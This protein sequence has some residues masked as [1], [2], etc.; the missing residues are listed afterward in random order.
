MFFSNLYEAMKDEYRRWRD[1][2]PPP[3]TPTPRPRTTPSTASPSPLLPSPARVPVPLSSG[4]LP[5]VKNWSH[6][7]GDTS[8]VFQQLTTLAKAQ[9]GYFPLGRNGLWHGGVHFDSGTAGTVGP[10]GQ[11][12]VRCLADGEVIAYRIPEQTPKTLFFPAP[13]V[14]IEAPFAS[15]FVLVRHRLEAPRIEGEADTPPSLIFY[16]LYMHLADWASYQADTGKARPAF[17]SESSRCRV[18]MTV[19]DVRPGHPE[20]RGL[21]LRHSPSRGKVIGFLPKGATVTVSGEGDYRKVEGIKGP[22]EL[23]N[24]DGT[25][26]GYVGFSALKDM[27]GGVYRVNTSRDPLTVR[28]VPNK[29]ESG[30]FK[31]PIGSEITISGEGE[32]RKL[33]SVVQYAHFASLESER[34]P[35]CGKVVVLEKPFPIKAGSLIGHLGPYQDSKE[36]APQEK[37]H[38][39]VFACEDVEA[40]FT[41]SRE[42]AARMPEKYKT[43]LKLEKGTKVVVHQASY[44]KTTPPNSAHPHVLSGAPL[45]IP[46]ALLDG[47]PADRKITVAASQSTQARNWYRLDN[48]LLDANGENIPMGWVCDEIGVTPWV[49]P[50]AWDGYEVIYNNDPPQNALAHFLLNLGNY[51]DEKELEQ[52]KPLADASD[53]GPVRQRLLDIIDANAD[54]TI[55][56]AEVQKALSIPAYAQSIS[57]LVIHNE[58]EWYYQQRKWDALDKVL[59]HTGS[60]PILNWVAEK[61]RIKELSWWGEVSAKRIL[62]ANGETYCLHPLPLIFMFVNGCACGRD[63]T[64]DEMRRIS[65]E[66]SETAIDAHLSSINQ[67]FN[68]FGIVTCRQK[69]HFLAQV[70]HESDKLYAVREYGGEDAAYA[71]WFGRGLLQLTFRANYEKYGAYVGDDVVSSDLARDKVAAPPHAALS[72]F[73]FYAKYKNLVSVAES[74]DLIMLTARINGGFNGYDERLKHFNSASKVLGGGHL[75]RL[76]SSG[77]FPFESSEAYK[78]KIYSL[79]WGIWHDPDRRE[80]GTS[81]DRSK[82]LAGYKRAKFLL[83]LSP[84]SLGTPNSMIYGIKYSDVQAFIDKRIAELNLE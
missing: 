5:A 30:I 45:L 35:Q 14:T 51:F 56:A 49:N 37:L 58:S 72:A 52:W 73:W 44:S 53:R 23:Q 34:V 82:S 28:P 42:W 39:E 1:G 13:G 21:N 11:G 76:E 65:P 74:D 24:P 3:P 54:G 77:K 4:D 70:L 9:A 26:R 33:E 41:K 40:F 19:K 12:Y 7:F 17:W 27:G 29:S 46:R 71:P 36:E 61:E 22:V 47:L 57:Q 38:L 18:K 31:L 75:S 60:T 68:R 2:T 84:M 62:S 66:S 20:E 81:K 83:S 6:P 16:S 80:R 43:W 25:L 8:S 32:F 79:A 10:E 50:W 64:K 63:I 15:G 55:T 59:G 67:G 78:N 48:L 69:A